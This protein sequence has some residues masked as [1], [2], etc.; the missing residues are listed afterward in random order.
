MQDVL[1]LDDEK[2]IR[3]TVR[4]CLEG[5]GLSV[6]E[7]LNGEEAFTLLAGKAYGLLLLDLKLPGM[8]GME[9]LR[10]VRIEYQQL[11]VIIISAH[12]SIQ[13]AVQAMKSGALD[14]L[15]KP[16]TPNDLRQVVL[17]ALGK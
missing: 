15:E 10:R 6:D 12:G 8:D 11:P 9:V 14:F 17:K 3:L 5:A 1:V 4:R 7:A 16:F 2:N 13:T